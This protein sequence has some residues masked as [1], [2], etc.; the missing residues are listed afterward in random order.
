MPRTRL[1]SI[2][3]RPGGRSAAFPHPPARPRTPAAGRA[4]LRRA[5]HPRRWH[6][7][8]CGEGGE[9]GGLGGGGRESFGIEERGGGGEG[10]PRGGPSRRAVTR[11]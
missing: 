2:E 3:P 11:G 9:S 5:A 10:G 8:N 6:P 1:T 4:T 7:Q